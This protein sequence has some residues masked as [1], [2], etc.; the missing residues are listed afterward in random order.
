MATVRKRPTVASKTVPQAR[1]NNY[2]NWKTLDAAT[3]MAAQQAGRLI[4]EQNK[5]NRASGK[6]PKV[7]KVDSNPVKGGI[8]RIGRMSGGGAGGMFG[9]KNR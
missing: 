1:Y 9:I 5:E 6:A 8:T 3:G 4:S 7:V 2:S